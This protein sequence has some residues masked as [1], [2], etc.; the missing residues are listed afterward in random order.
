MDCCTR[1]RERESK[2]E[3]GDN[4]LTQWTRNFDRNDGLLCQRERER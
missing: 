1:E 4:M 2:Q 3:Q